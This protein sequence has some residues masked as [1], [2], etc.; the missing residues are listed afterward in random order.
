[1][2][3]PHP[4][5]VLAVSALGFA[6]LGG[7]GTLALTS[8]LA[9]GN[10]VVNFTP[11]AAAQDSTATTAAR[12]PKDGAGCHH[13]P[14]DDATAAKVKAAAEQAVPDATVK[15]TAHD[16]SNTEGYVA[17]ME[18]ADGARVLVHED[19]DFKVTK[20]EDPAPLRGPGGPRR[21]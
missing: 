21:S 10:P 3:T 7:L 9:S 16:R 19:A 13:E 5:R 2:N 15:H 11:A 20:V 6:A 17:M 1:M 14:L 12:A 8:A 4:R 18:K